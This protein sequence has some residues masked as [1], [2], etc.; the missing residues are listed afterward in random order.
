[1]S[2]VVNLAHL[3]QWIS[4]HI[5]QK[6]PFQKLLLHLSIRNSQRRYI[7]TDTDTV[8]VVK[9]TFLD[10]P[11]GNLLKVILFDHMNSIA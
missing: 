10:I 11:S 7:F 2:N 1:M 9:H 3:L 8:N 5:M 6:E 4:I